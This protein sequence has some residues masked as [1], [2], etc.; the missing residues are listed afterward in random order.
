M[1]FRLGLLALSVIPTAQYPNLMPP[2]ITVTVSY[3]GASA[4]ALITT[5]GQPIE[6]QVQPAHAALF[7]AHQGEVTIVRL[8]EVAQ[9]IRRRGD[10]VQFDPR[11]DHDAC[12]SAN[13]GGPSSASFADKASSAARS[14]SSAPR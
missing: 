14:T 4:T 6:V 7:D 3:P 10:A 12:A 1:R 2:K 11:C 9:I 5:V 13:S 8:H